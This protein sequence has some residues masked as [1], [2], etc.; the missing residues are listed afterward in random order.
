M[1]KSVMASK[2]AGSLTPLLDAP[3]QLPPGQPERLELTE[4]LRTLF[5][6]ESSEPQDTHIHILFRLDPEPPEQPAPTSY[7]V[8]FESGV[9]THFTEE[10]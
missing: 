1:V 5:D 4:K 9:F 7:A 2:E 8:R 10:D 6:L 3:L